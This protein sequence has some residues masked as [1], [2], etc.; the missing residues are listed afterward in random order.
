MSVPKSKRGQSSMEFYHNALTLRHE[1][2]T[3]LL[4]DFGLKKKVRSIEILTKMYEIEDVDKQTLLNI[5]N[6]YKMDSSIIDEYPNWL[7]AEFRQSI[8]YILREMSLNIKMANSIYI[9]TKEEYT[10]RREYWDKAIGNCQQ[11]LAEMQFVIDILPVN[12]EKLM[13]YVGMIDKE[14]NLLKGV[15]KSDNKALGRLWKRLP[16][17]LIFAM[18][19]TMVMPTTTMRRILTAFAL[20]FLDTQ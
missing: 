9:Q 7:I 1:I 12:A 14:I 11:L 20:D 16:R 3:L 6:K 18:S 4:R 2:T 15:R 17:P 10:M 8:L 19:T 5:L 13:R